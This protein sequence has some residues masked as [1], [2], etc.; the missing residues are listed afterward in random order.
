MWFFLPPTWRFTGQ[1]RKWGS[2]QRVWD[3]TYAGISVELVTGK[4]GGESCRA[5]HSL[6]ITLHCCW[7]HE[8]IKWRSKH[9]SIG[10]CLDKVAVSL[11]AFCKLWSISAVNLFR[12]YLKSSTRCDLSF[13]IITLSGIS[14]MAQTVTKYLNFN[15]FQDRSLSLNFV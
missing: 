7:S 15:S 14:S 6:V 12:L 2:K 8:E 13:K 11:R 3:K 4:R 10:P 1:R 5:V 9:C